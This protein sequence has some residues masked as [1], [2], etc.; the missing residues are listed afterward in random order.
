MV[1]TSFKGY[2]LEMR[3]VDNQAIVAGFS[4]PNGG[5]LLTCDGQV[6]SL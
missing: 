2:I 6:C 4:V 5:K 1:T 3:R